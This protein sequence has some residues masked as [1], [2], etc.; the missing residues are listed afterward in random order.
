MNVGILGTGFGAYHASIYKKL[1]SID[2]ITIYGRNKEKLEKIEKDMEIKVT[3]NIDDILTSKDIHLIDICLP[4]LLHKEYVIEALKNGKNVFCETPISLNLEDA[5]AMREAEKQYGKRVFVNLFIKHEYPYEYVYDTIQKNALGK[6]KAL[7]VRRKTP[8][9]WGDLSL[10]KIT[11]NLM[12]H[13]FDFVTWMLGTPNKIS[14]VGINGNE[15]QSHVNALLAYEDS[16]I[17][18]QG[19][20]MMPEYHPFTVGYEAIFEK[21]TIEYIENGYVNKCE[22]A[23]TLFTNNSKEDLDIPEK[24][25]YEESIKHV[26]E[27]CIKDISTILSLEDAIK[28]LKV[29]LQIKEEIAKK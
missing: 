3:E 24:D 19:S 22:K 20:S 7:H 11:T 10:N 15:G 28:S 6:L 1:S 26:V 27:C 9:L 25:C 14:A 21:G 16:I 13:E 4:S 17:E 23:L 2:S 5:M 29:A 12:I 8:P 18:I